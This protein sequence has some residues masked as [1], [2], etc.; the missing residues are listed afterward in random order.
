VLCLHTAGV[1]GSDLAAPT[2]NLFL[3][4][5]NHFSSRVIHPVP[6]NDHWVRAALDPLAM[7]HHYAVGETD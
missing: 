6:Q 1:A 4:Q 3:H 7:P 5:L 2:I